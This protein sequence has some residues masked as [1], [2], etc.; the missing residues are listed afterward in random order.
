MN[1]DYQDE[2]SK[3]LLTIKVSKHS[4]HETQYFFISLTLSLPGG[5][6]LP[7]TVLG[8][9]ELAETSE[10]AENFIRGALGVVKLSDEEK[11]SKRYLGASHPWLKN[12]NSRQPNQQGQNDIVLQKHE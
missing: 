11:I 2:I 5:Q 3:P 7:D 4:S 1:S 8:F 12:T 6:I 9:C 10:V